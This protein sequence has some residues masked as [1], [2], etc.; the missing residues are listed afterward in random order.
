MRGTYFHWNFRAPTLTS[1]PQW[2]EKWIVFPGYFFKEKM[3]EGIMFAMNR[4]A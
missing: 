1:T 4:N 3:T 2:A